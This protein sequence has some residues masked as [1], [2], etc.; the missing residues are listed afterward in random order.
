MSQTGSKGFTC[1][2]I[3]LGF[4]SECQQPL[5]M[6][7]NAISDGHISAPSQLTS[8]HGPNMARL[9]LIEGTG[10]W[11]AGTD[12]NQWLQV[13][14]GVLYTKVTGIATQGRHDVSWPMWVTKY[15]IQYSDDGVAFQNYIEQGQSAVKVKYT[16]STNLKI[17]KLHFFIS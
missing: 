6:E 16:Y 17:I 13:D 4:L 8:Y 10:G 3:Y 9:N 15:K 14:L 11:R 12:S 5:G 1:I 2:Y 7:N